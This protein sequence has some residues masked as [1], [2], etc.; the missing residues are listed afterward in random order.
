MKSL[1]LIA[2]FYKL[3]LKS[4]MEYRF[5]FF[6]EIFINF[7][8]YIVDYIALWILLS[9]F[10]E[11]HGWGY[12]EMMLL[13]NMNLMTYGLASLFFYIPMRN[14]ES[15]VSDG[16]F[17]SYLIRP[18]HPFCYL[19]LRQSYLGFLSHVILGIS[20]FI[21]C[22]RHMGLVW[23]AGLILLFVSCLIGGTL[24][25]S[26]VI[27]AAGALNIRFVKANALMD[28]LIYNIRSFIEYPIDIYPRFIQVLV[29]VVIPYAFVNFYP[30]SLLLNKKEPTVFMMAAP[31]LIGT[32]MF[33][34]AYQ[35]FNICV[36]AYQGV[37]N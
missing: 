35:I 21:L 1:K 13:Y 32:G 25:Q 27:V 6:L 23:N 15:I 33:A 28:T 20:I 26:S 19:L 11:I 22:F 4:K 12:Y 34:L 14:L 16:E 2:V 18:I 24:I 30:A 5:H 9:N 31:L 8:T 10:R 36:N 37:G 17:D 7:F 29:T 3:L